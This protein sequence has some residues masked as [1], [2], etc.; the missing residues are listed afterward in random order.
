MTKRKKMN[1]DNSKTA[2]LFPPA[3]SAFGLWEE[4]EAEEKEKKRTVGGREFAATAMK[5][6]RAPSFI[7]AFS[8]GDGRRYRMYFC[9]GKNLW[10]FKKGLACHRNCL[11]TIQSQFNLS[12]EWQLSY[13]NVFFVV[14]LCVGKVLSIGRRPRETKL[15]CVKIPREIEGFRGK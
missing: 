1:N 2:E 9:M 5:Y 10:N 14:Q 6:K 15:L 12:N 3:L 11:R 7:L 13:A 4:A 8:S